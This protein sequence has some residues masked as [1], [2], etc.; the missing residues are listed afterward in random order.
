MK[1]AV[2]LLATL[3]IS[4]ISLCQSGF[5]EFEDIIDYDETYETLESNMGE[6]NGVDLSKFWLDNE[7]ERR[8]GFI[9]ANYRRLRIKFLS[10][11]KNVDHPTQY[12]IYGK[13]NVSDH[14]CEFQGVIEIKESYYV[15][16]NEFPYGNTGILAGFYTFYEDP[17]MMHSGTFKGRFVTYWYKDKNGDIR[18]NDLLAVSAMYNNNQFA[19]TWMQYGKRIEKI[20]NWGDRRIPN[21]GDLDV[22]TSEFC[23]SQKYGANGWLPFRIANG[24]KSDRMDVESVRTSENREWWKED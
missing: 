12:L 14:I 15:K 2:I 9:G 8:F 10:I 17:N 5:K 7:N 18:Y 22:G 20:A 4:Q 1:H 23:P 13:S 3:L 6:L 24:M 16:T 21:S 19:G 11:I